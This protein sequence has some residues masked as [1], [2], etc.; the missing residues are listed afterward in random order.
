M[1]QNFPFACGVPQVWSWISG[2]LIFLMMGHYFCPWK[3]IDCHTIKVAVTLYILTCVL[4]AHWKT[5]FMHKP[6]VVS[7]EQ[8]AATSLII[9]STTCVA[10]K[11]WSGNSQCWWSAGKFNTIDASASL[12]HRLIICVQKRLDQAI[13]KQKAIWQGRGPAIWLSWCSS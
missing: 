6:V 9:L 7:A 5:C 11:T 12:A 13:F 1:R 2:P 3:V 4:L 10:N 8:V